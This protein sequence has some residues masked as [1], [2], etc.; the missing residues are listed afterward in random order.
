[1][2][3]DKKKNS[4]V[5]TVVLLVLLAAIIIGLIVV[6]VKMLNNNKDNVK[7]T[8]TDKLLEKNLDE[9]YPATESEVIKLYCRIQQQMYSG[10]CSDEEIQGLFA[11]M[12]KLYDEE[13]LAENS[14]DTQYKNLL[15]ELESYKKNKVKITNYEILQKPGDVTKGEYEGREQALIDVCFRT[16]KDSER[17]SL[18]QEFVLRKDDEGRW[19]ILG[20]YKVEGNSGEEN[21]E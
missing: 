16:K 18:I 5:S 17:Q 14:Y 12:R 4:K 15:D 7:I 8:E 13:L 11:Q 3:S 9:S 2:A 19:K 6:F 20:W 21:D 1:M 10:E